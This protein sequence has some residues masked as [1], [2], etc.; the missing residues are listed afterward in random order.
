LSEFERFRE[1]I[2]SLQA[3]LSQFKVGFLDR[4]AFKDFA[5]NLLDKV[6]G[7]LNL[8]ITG[9]FSETIR[10]ALGRIITMGCMV[11]LICQEFDSAH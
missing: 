2:V 7:Y 9:Y 11:R 8:R 3:D 1:K 4:I 6:G 10:E 5:D